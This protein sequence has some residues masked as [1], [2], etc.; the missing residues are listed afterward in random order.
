MANS[1]RSKVVGKGSI[2]F[3]SHDGYV[4]I[5]HGVSH[6][7][8]SRCNLISL[9]AL[10]REGFQFRSDCGLMEISKMAC[11]TFAAKLVGN[12]YELQGS[13]V[14]S[15]GVQISSASK[16]EI[17]KQSL[18]VSGSV[19]V[20]PEGK[21]LRRCGHYASVS[22]AQCSEVGAMSHGSRLDK[23]D[24]WVIMFRSGLNLFDLTKL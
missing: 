3:R 5:L 1:S 7:P 11:V 23:G 20:D 4:T 17:V 6:V 8:G 14:I 9:G 16:S 13:W 18:C 15:G 19:R 10:H 21:R 12:V 24:R 2:Q 22:P